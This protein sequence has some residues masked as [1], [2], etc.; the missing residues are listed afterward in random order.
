MKAKTVWRGGLLVLGLGDE[1][2]GGEIPIEEEMATEI[3][4]LV[5]SMLAQCVREDGSR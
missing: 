1:G 5:R 3:W 2:G 4:P